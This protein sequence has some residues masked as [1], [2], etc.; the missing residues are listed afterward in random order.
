LKLVNSPFYAFPRK[1]TT[2]PQ[3]I[4]IIGYSALRNLVL[5]KS[6]FDLFPK[7]VGADNFEYEAF[8]KHSIACGVGAK[9][10]AKACEYD[11]IE[12]MFVS[13]LL[14]DIGKIV[15]EQ[16]LRD[17]FSEALSHAAGNRTTILYA[18]NEV[19]GFCH[20]DTGNLAVEK[21][22]L[23]T[24]LVECVAYHHKPKHADR[25]R[26]QVSMVHLANVL[27][28]ALKFGSSGQRVLSGVDRF[29]WDTL[30][31]PL[32]ALEPVMADMIVQFDDAVN[33]VM[34]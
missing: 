5:T 16:F 7:F 9:I 15:Q 27:A 12:E 3:A 6:A 14:H 20:T 11:E 8:W 4:V 2:I 25:H 10:L 32:S 34:S 24:V 33:F 18:E 30:E 28:H 23:P 19:M 29:A 1:I 21:W 13:G 26:K 17:S 22:N 31:L